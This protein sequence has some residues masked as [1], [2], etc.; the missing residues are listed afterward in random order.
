MFSVKGALVPLTPSDSIIMCCDLKFNSEANVFLL[1][2]HFRQRNK[3]ISRIITTTHS[4]KHVYWEVNNSLKLLWQPQ[5]PTQVGYPGR[6][7]DVGFT[8]LFRKRL[9]LYIFDRYSEL[10]LFDFYF[11]V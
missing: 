8:K 11:Q 10:L 7:L 3:I 1:L 4:Y 5:T 9:F 6:T 2:W